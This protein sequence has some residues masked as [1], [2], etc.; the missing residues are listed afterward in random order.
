MCPGGHTGTEMAMSLPCVP[1][2]LL[3]QPVH[4]RA[5]LMFLHSPVPFVGS[6][7]GLLGGHECVEDVVVVVPGAVLLVL[8]VVGPLLGLDLL[9]EGDDLAGEVIEASVRI[10][11]STFLLFVGE[12]TVRNGFLPSVVFR[13]PNPTVPSLTSS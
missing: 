7:L 5:G 2:G 13:N 1:S 3:C 4:H 10:S 9:R 6:E 11:V 8:A 12:S